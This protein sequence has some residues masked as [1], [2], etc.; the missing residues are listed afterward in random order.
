MLPEFDVYGSAS[1]ESN[2][3]PWAA[4]A[5]IPDV[6]CKL[7]CVLGHQTPTP[8]SEHG[9]LTI[10]DHVICLAPQNVLPRQ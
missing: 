2:V 5:Q 1:T 10:V 9:V 4:A 8:V 7:S 6:S 3:Q